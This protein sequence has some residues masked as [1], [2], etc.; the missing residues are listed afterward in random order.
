[1]CPTPFKVVP[2]QRRREETKRANIASS[3]YFNMLETPAAG[4]TT[5]RSFPVP[6]GKPCGVMLFCLFMQGRSPR[7]K[8]SGNNYTD[9]F[10]PE[11]KRPPCLSNCSPRKEG[12]VAILCSAR[13]PAQSRSPRRGGRLLQQR[14]FLLQLA[15]L[16][17]NGPDEDAKDSLRDEVGR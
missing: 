7:T 15:L 14:A 5:H 11:R 8:S 1:M 3:I 16:R 2:L 10:S 17:S 4:A 9:P 6:E 13:L 12:G